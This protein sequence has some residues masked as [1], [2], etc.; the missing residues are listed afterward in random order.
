MKAI[1]SLAA[2][3]MLALAGCETAPPAEPAYDPA[4]DAHMVEAYF[5]RQMR[6]AILAQH[7]IYP[8]HFDV[9]SASL[10]ELGERDLDLLARHLKE[11]PGPLGVRQGDASDEVYQAR[12]DTVRGFLMDTGVP[13]DRIAIAD[14]LPG[15]DG[16]VSDRVIEVLA[17]PSVPEESYNAESLVTVV[18]GQ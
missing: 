14:A 15:G 8:Y 11:N 12:V 2:A 1:W 16:A 10:N 6:N 9:Y 4:L 18:G 17:A 13:A 7:T 5:S 3:C